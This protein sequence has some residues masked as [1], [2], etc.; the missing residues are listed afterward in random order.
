LLPVAAVVFGLV[1]CSDATDRISTLVGASPSASANPSDRLRQRLQ[2]DCASGRGSILASDRSAANQCSCYADTMMKAMSKNDVTY[3]ANYGIV[4]T[5]VNVNVEDVKKRCAEAAPASI[6]KG[7]S[8]AKLG[9][10]PVKP[11]TAAK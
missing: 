1:A 3:F 4:P 11:G 2:S 8:P 9:A 10:Q 5:V 6:K 7:A